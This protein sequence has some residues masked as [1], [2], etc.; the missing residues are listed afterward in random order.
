LYTAHEVAV[1]TAK[2]CPLLPKTDASHKVSELA[3]Q[4]RKSV[5]DKVLVINTGLGEGGWIDKVL[6]S[7]LPEGGA[8]QELIDENFMEGWAGEV[9]E[10]WN[11]SVV[12]FSY[13]KKPLKNLVK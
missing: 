13:F 9:A 2:A 10:S 6:E 4:L 1:A 12:G 5:D 3:E 7:V 8:L 11:D